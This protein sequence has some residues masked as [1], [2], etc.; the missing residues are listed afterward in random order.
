VPVVVSVVLV[1]LVLLALAFLVA[2]TAGV[3]GGG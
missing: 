3:L 1:V 2:Q